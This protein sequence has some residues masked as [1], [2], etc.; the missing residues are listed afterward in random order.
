MKEGREE[1]LFPLLSAINEEL[2]LRVTGTQPQVGPWQVADHSWGT[3]SLALLA[4]Y[5][6]QALPPGGQ[7][8]PSVRESQKVTDRS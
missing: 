1:N 3:N 6:S 4:L 5:T 7:R 8:I 2:P